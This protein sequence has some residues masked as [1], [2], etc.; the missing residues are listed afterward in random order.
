MVS[1]LRRRLRN[2]LE[3]PATWVGGQ[4]EKARAQKSKP[5]IPSPS[6]TPK[7]GSP[8]SLFLS[9][10]IPGA[11]PPIPQHLAWAH[12]DKEAENGQAIGAPGGGAEVPI[13]FL[14]E[15]DELHLRGDRREWGPP[16]EGEE[17]MGPAVSL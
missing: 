14:V 1:R 12:I 15:V 17:R 11:Q 5:P 4:G 2:G 3:L 8:A 6:R 13:E 7:S 9:P 10:Q 16:A